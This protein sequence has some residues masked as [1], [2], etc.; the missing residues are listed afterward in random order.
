MFDRR[1]LCT[2]SRWASACTLAGLVGNAAFAQALTD[3]YLDGEWQENKACTG[4]ADYTFGA[5]FNTFQVGAGTPATYKITGPESITLDPN[6]SSPMVLKLQHVDADTMLIYMAGSRSTLYRCRKAGTRAAAAAPPPPAAPAPAPVPY[7]PPVAAPL[8]AAPGFFGGIS[9]AFLDGK[10]KNNGL[11]MGRT[12]VTFDQFGNVTFDGSPT[13]AYT[14]TAP[15]QIM[16]ASRAGPV[17]MTVTY[18][19]PNKIVINDGRGNIDERWRCTP[20]PA[21]F[22]APPPPP[23]AMPAGVMLTP[24]LLVGRWTSVGNCAAAAATFRP[25]GS[26]IDGTGVSARWSL[27]GNLLTYSVPGGSDT[28]VLRAINANAIEQSDSS[29]RTI[30]MQRCP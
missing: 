6:G 1:Q 21:G 14:V 22:A 3:A 7:T 20:T 30:V 8:P 27:G 26:F 15:N 13:T 28:V 11:C 12:R 24:A 18:V 16:V 19:D 29:G 17:Y 10:W 2:L 4:P 9:V 5:F 25:D 23:A